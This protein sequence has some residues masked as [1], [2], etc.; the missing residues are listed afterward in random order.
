MI[1]LL[2]AIAVVATATPL[3]A[4]NKKIVPVE[5][6]EPGGAPVAD[7]DKKYCA[8]IVSRVAKVSHRE[9]RTRAQW[10]KKG[11]DPLVPAS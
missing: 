2:A 1:R 7:A 6:V 8:N 3:V 9:C 4:K 11:I 5:Q 10:M